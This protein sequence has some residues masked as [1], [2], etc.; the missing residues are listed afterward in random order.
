ML[1]AP[2]PSYYFELSKT[3]FENE[4]FTI[5]VDLKNSGNGCPAVLDYWFGIVE[6]EKKPT[7]YQIE[8]QLNGR[9][10]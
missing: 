6:I 4:V 5:E 7:D 2:C 10:W 8:I 9:N 1:A 3:S